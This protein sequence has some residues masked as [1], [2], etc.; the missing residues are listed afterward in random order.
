[1]PQS[2]DRALDLIDAVA[3]ASGPVTAKALARRLGCGLSTVY[4]LLGSLTERGHLE[5]TAAGYT[6]GYRVPTLHSA[7]RRQQRIDER[8]HESLLR[9]RRLS[10]ADVFFSTYRD[11]EITV[12]DGATS[13]P[14]SVFSVGRDTGAHATAHGRMLLSSLPGAA[15]RQY[16]AAG[17]LPPRT[18]HTITSAERLERELR[19][20]RRA[21]VAVEVEQAAPGM[22]CVAVPLPM[23]PAG[24]AA[25]GGVRAGGTAV[26][27][28]VP[29]AEFQR[30]REPLI[31]ALRREAAA[32]ASS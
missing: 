19:R 3:E 28:A 27:A 26:S 29:V 12:V 15:R 21:G 13:G 14:D 22:A 20:V 1:M 16:L 17:G 32:L 24:G 2:V 4:A 25:A 6:L 23:A 31:E 7:F 10:G 5:R 8:V 18:P 30:L 9:L 11:G